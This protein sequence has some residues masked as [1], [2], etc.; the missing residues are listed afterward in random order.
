MLR[1]LQAEMVRKGIG[2]KDI[3]KVIG[4]DEK[5]V[6]RK[7]KEESVFTFPEAM[8]IKEVFFKEH[9]L[10]MLFCTATD[11]ESQQAKTKAM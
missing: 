3:A 1:N 6:R 8:K 10:Q 9:S 5:T 7:I 4:K 11:S 2:I